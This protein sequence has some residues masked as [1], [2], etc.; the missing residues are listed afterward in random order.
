MKY[1]ICPFCKTEIEDGIPSL[2]AHREVGG[3]CDKKQL[4]LHPEWFEE[5]S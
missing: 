5:K 2:I 3:V 4:E 1:Y